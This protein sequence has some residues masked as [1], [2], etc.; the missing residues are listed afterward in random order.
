MCGIGTYKFA[1]GN[2]YEGNWED[3]TRAGQGKMTYK[4]GAVYEGEWQGD[5]CHGKGKWTDEN[6]VYEGE[7]SGNQ[8]KGQG[9][10]TYKDGTKFDGQW[11]GD[12]KKD[13]KLTDA[14]GQVFNVTFDDTGK[15]LTQEKVVEKVAAPPAAAAPAPAPVPE[16]KPAPPPAKDPQLVAKEIEAEK[17]KLQQ[18]AAP[19]DPAQSEQA[20]EQLQAEIK[21]AVGDGFKKVTTMKPAAELPSGWVGPIKVALAGGEKVGKTALATVFVEDR[22]PAEYDATIHDTY[23]VCCEKDR[24]FVLDVQDIGGNDEFAS[25]QAD[26][27]PTCEVYVFCF[28]VVDRKSY[29]HAAQLHALVKQHK[30][31]FPHVLVGLQSDK[32]KIYNRAVSVSEAW[33]LAKQWGGHYIEASAKTKEHVPEVFQLAVQAYIASR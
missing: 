25:V 13:G 30:P 18:Q 24:V 2:V 17:A 28:S 3:G 5:K 11:D 7:F 10:Y 1:N 32:E 4:N 8:K 9:V 29:D 16:P 23:M 19:A 26:V 6:G 22:F 21:A 31:A 12:K 27:L 14:S 20:K 33:E 15:V